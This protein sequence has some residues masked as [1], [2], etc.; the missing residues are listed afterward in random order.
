MAVDMPYGI[1]GEIQVK[2]AGTKKFV[3]DRHEEDSFFA[4]HIYFEVQTGNGEKPSSPTS[5]VGEY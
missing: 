5:L 2:L 4:N 3:E 1:T